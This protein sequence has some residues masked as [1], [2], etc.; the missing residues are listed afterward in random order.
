M[1][2]QVSVSVVVV[3]IMPVASN[4]LAGTVL[5]PILAVLSALSLSFL[6]RALDWV[7]NVAKNPQK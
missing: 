5:A 7:S 6:Q 1:V 4:L 2:L 3:S